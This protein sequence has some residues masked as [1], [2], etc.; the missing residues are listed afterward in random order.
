MILESTFSERFR[1]A[2]QH[3]KYIVHELGNKVK[4]LGE[5]R[6]E[7]LQS[8][9]E[10]SLTDLVHINE[11]IREAT[12]SVVESVFVATV[13]EHLHAYQPTSKRKRDAAQHGEPIP[14]IHIP[15]KPHKNGLLDYL[16]VTYISHPTKSNKVL[17]F[18]LDHEP[19][20]RVGGAAP[21][22]AMYNLL[23]RWP[24]QLNKPHIIGDAAFGSL[25]TLKI[26]EQKGFYATLSVPNNQPAWLWNA[27]E[28][29]VPADHW[30][31]VRNNQGW[32]ASVHTLVADSGTISYHNILS[33]GF[34]SVEGNQQFQPHSTTN[35]P[36]QTSDSMPY[37]ATETLEQMTIPKL[38]EIC[39]KYNISQGKKKPDYVRNITKRVESTHKNTTELIAFQKQLD[40]FFLSEPAPPHDLYGDRFNLVDLANRYWYKAWDKH[41]TMSWKFKILKGTLKFSTLNC[42]VFAIQTKYEKWLQYR[43]QLAKALVCYGVD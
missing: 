29:A 37:F 9:L 6:F 28:Y 10:P 24:A 31:Y 23:D 21:Q 35:Q 26:I 38:R 15:R 34:V 7:Q 30:R 5:R 40:T 16:L 39:R 32:I 14:V 8:S 19:Y 43:M 1:D 4:G 12:K 2:R 22:Q 11:I 41:G 25:E 27:L 36:L 13:D 17:P 18:V 20:L 3:Y 42:W 33:N